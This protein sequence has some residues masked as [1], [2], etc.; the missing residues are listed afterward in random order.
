MREAGALAT[1]SAAR[2]LDPRSLV[3]DRRLLEVDG[4]FRVLLEHLAEHGPAN[5]PG[6]EGAARI[7][8]RSLA[9][10]KRHFPLLAGR[11]WQ[12]FVRRWRTA[13]ARNLL[14]APLASEKAIARTCGFRST[15]ALSK[16]FKTEFGMTPR[17]FRA[18]RR[19]KRRY[20]PEEEGEEE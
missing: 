14:T 1:R 7:A 4:G 6:R 2:W 10:F 3:A 9:T 20:G 16:A 13:C 5:V 18:S 17:A 12:G 8:G 11:P 19:R 15:G